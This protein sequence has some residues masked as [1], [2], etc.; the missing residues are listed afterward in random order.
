MRHAR[1][2]VKKVTIPQKTKATDTAPAKEW[3]VDYW[4]LDYRRDGKRIRQYFETKKAADKALSDLNTKWKNEGQNALDL[5]HRQRVEAFESFRRLSQYNETLTSA[6]NFYIKHLEATKKGITVQAM[7]DEFLN[8][9]RRKNQSKVHKDDLFSRY[10]RFCATFGSRL[11]HEVTDK[12]VAKWLYSMDLA[13]VSFNNWTDRISFLFG[14]GVENG[15]LDKNPIDKRLRR[16]NPIDEKVEVFSV[17]DITKLLCAAAE[18]QP[19]LVPM[20]ALGAFTGVRI[21]ELHRLEYQDINFSTGF[22]EVAGFKA[23]SRS[24]RKIPIQPNLLEWLIPYS[25]QSGLIWTSTKTVFQHRIAKL[26][27]DTGVTRRK[28]GLRHSYATYHINLWE[29]ENKLSIEMGHRSGNMIFAHYKGEATKQ[30]AERYFQI[31]PPTPA[32][33]IVQMPAAA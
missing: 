4:M 16:E 8:L 24:H 21:A 1:I 25:G 18:G 30:D 9:P 33:N 20:I 19:E 6:V 32:G 31:R 29:D 7:V 3:E 15:Y 26:C 22:V 2:Q 17:D 28:N 10:T 23:K 5:S 27:R 12:E 13:P 11:V 14:Y